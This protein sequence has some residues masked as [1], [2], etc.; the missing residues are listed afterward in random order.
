[1]GIDLPAAGEQK[2]TC[3]PYIGN[4][5]GCLGLKKTLRIRLRREFDNLAV[6]QHSEIG[7]LER[8]RLPVAGT[9]L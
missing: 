6:E 5:I 7:R 2:E 3:F 1:M 4:C 8:R 9:V